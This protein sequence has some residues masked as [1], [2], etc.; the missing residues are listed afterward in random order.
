MKNKISVTW[1]NAANAWPGAP[2]N[3]AELFFYALKTPDFA[4]KTAFFQR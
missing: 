3:A 4:R 1:R 2:I